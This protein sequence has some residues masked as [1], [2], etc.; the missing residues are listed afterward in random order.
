MAEIVIRNT[1]ERIT[2][3]ENVREFLNNQEVVYEH[4]NMEKLPAALQENFKLSDDDKKRILDI[5]D[6]EIRD[7]AA[8]RGY[9]IWDVITLSES[10][11]NI[12]D[13]LKKFEEVHTHSE[14]E[15]RAIV[16]G[17]GIFIIKGSDDVGYFNVEL[18]PGDVIS[19]PENTPHFFTLMENKQIIAVR[20]FIEENGWVATPVADP[21]FQ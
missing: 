8:R 2:G 6:V 17:K 21:Q 7:L 18:E 20:L 14:D 11:P 4:W 9:K 15:I 19:V 3:E 5:F 10:T 1:N 12:E 13:L 16:G